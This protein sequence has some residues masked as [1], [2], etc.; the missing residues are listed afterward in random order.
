MQTDRNPYVRYVWKRVFFFFELF[1]KF[2]SATLTFAE[3]CQQPHNFG[4]FH[5][6]A[7]GLKYEVDRYCGFDAVNAVKINADID[8]CE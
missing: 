3:I 1:Q 5:Y 2:Y 6:F 7:P 4:L 8:D